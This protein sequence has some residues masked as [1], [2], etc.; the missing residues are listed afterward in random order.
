MHLVGIRRSLVEKYPWLPASL[1]KAFS[2][3]KAVA[4]ADLHDINALLVTLPWLVAEA[5]ETEA[6]MGKDFWKYGVKENLKEIEALTQYSLEQG[7][8][9]RKVDASEL[10]VPST[11]EMSKV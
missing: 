4:M 1:F 9:S 6:L 8:S 11:Y 3:A 10:F 2:E 5:D 7:L